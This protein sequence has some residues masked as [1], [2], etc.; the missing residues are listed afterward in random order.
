MISTIKN[1]ILHHII[2]KDIEKQTI[3]TNSII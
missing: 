3:A 1:V 2:N